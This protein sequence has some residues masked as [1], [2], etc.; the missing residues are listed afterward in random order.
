MDSLREEGA[1]DEDMEELDNEQEDLKQAKI[2][3]HLSVCYEKVIQIKKNPQPLKLN[4][5][6]IDP[7]HTKK[8]P[9][10]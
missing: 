3:R 9:Q 6:L 7:I 8:L 4:F 2:R 5:Q 1:E 10:D